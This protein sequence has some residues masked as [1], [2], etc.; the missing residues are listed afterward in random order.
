[1]TALC[2]P[3]LIGAEAAIQRFNERKL[4]NLYGLLARH[5]RIA[6]PDNPG[7]RKPPFIE[8]LWLPAYAVCVHS[9]LRDKEI[10]TWTTVD[11]M[12]GYF[13]FLDSKEDLAPRELA[14]ESFPP[15]VTRDQAEAAARRGLL[16]FIMRQ[17]G[18]FNKP[19]IEAVG[20]IQLYHSPV[21]V[22][23]FHSLT[24]R[25]DIKVLDAYTGKPGG[26][27][28]RVGVLDALI[29]ARKQRL[30]GPAPLRTP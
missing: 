8:R 24:R 5:I 7:S 12:A 6:A 4:R 3:S 17:R 2:L 25:V 10:R 19:L 16:Q 18:Q 21:W 29:A 1:M 30:A 9:Q 28:M 23:Y 14:E 20:E 22:L 11:G 27:K 13:A 26:A 15:V